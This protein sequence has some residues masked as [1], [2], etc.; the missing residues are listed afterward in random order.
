M[1]S[2]AKVI[3]HIDLNAFFA[4]VASINEPYLKNKVFVV[5]GTNLTTRGVITTASYKARRKGIKS[6]MSIVEATKIY[7]KLLVVPTDYTENKKYSDIFF[8]V[9]KEYSD[10]VLKGSIDEAYVDMTELSKKYHPLQIAKDIMN[11]LNKEYSLPVSIGIAPTLFLA[12]MASDLKKPLGITVVR[13]KDIVKK[14]LPL[15]IKDLFG[16]GIKTYPIL[17]NKGIN[18]IGD[19]IKEENRETILSVMS[20]DSYNH[21]LENIKGLSSDIVNPSKYD[22][23]KSISSETTFNYDVGNVEAIM[24]EMKNLFDESYNRLIKEKVICKTVT[25]KIRYSDF[26]TITRS[27][28][29]EDFTKDYHTLETLMEE[30]FYDNYND[31]ELRLVG[32]G[33]SNMI[34]EE[35]YRE[36][37]N[38]F[39]YQK[40]IK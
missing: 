11:R 13:K 22:I 35:D 32:V 8:N 2:A 7:P 4:S 40:L 29:I 27:K 25:I 37:F 3:F 33:F 28:S 31:E 20:I 19:F 30:I 10:L 6:G 39:T 14:I 18:L 34:L 1:K 15:P 9:L 12:K 5:G 24:L 17:M 16:L 38:L 23:P 26:Q 21:F 36:D